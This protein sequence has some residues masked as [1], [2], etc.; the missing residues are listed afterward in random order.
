MRPCRWVGVGSGVM[1]WLAHLAA[2]VSA[3]TATEAPVNITL[4]QAV[5][6]ALVGN[7]SLAVERREVDIA[8]GIR[9]QAGSTTVQS[10]AGGRGGAGRARD[11]VDA[12][13]AAASMRRA[14]ACPRR[15][16]FKG[17]GDSR[18]WCDAGLLRATRRCRMPNARSW[19]T[20]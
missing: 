15:S 7:P 20:Y 12:T 11:R 18:A 17:N 14:W 13:I 16:G 5:S 1:L 9:R 8:K 3:A 10:R 6:E 4:Q 19:R 2:G